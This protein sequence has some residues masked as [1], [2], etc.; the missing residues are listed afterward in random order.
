MVTS[1]ITQEKKKMIL[2]GSKRGKRGGRTNVVVEGGPK[3]CWNRKGRKWVRK[4]VRALGNRGGDT[5][6]AIGVRGAPFR[7]TNGEGKKPSIILRTNFRKP[8]L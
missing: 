1:S 7:K 4:R 5:E 2:G 6:S 3:E 8:D